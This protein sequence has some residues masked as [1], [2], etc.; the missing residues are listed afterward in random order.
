MSLRK[1]MWTRFNHTQAG[2]NHDQVFRFYDPKWIFGADGP[3]ACWCQQFP[4]GADVRKRDTYQFGVY[5]GGT[6]AGQVYYFHELRLRVGTMWGF[7]SFVG[8][9][10]E[11]EGHPLVTKNWRVGAYSAAD[12]FR[13]WRWERLEARILQR[14]NRS[15]ADGRVR[16]LRGFFNDTL[17]PR[18]AMER[19]MQPALYVDVDA[20]LYISSAQCLDWLFCSG[21]MSAG[22]VNGTLV[23]YDD[24]GG[25]TDA[26]RLL[27]ER[28]AHHEITNRHNV[29]WRHAAL[30]SNWFRVES[31]R[32]DHKWC[33]ARG[34][35]PL[36]PNIGRDADA[37][38]LA[39]PSEEELSACFHRTRLWSRPFVSRS[40][41]KARCSEQYLRYLASTYE[42]ALKPA[43][44]MRNWS[45]REQ[46]VV[47]GETRATRSRHDG[48]EALGGQDAMVA[49]DER[50][51]TEACDGEPV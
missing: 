31:Y 32:L 1:G 18:L 9:P 3:L 6:M 10:P 26:K 46:V 40:G 2:F 48:R 23:R 4:Y 37:A 11:Q 49:L 36:P 47:S 14:I 41:T 17:Q 27:G 45:A 13:T 7:D 21:L 28:L 38:V 39:T 25:P 35:P 34:Y 8:L 43:H 33:A 42:W 22:S 12:A 15:A 30:L 16:L 24:W 5:T 51:E 19:R 29:R 50:L 44:E 20:D